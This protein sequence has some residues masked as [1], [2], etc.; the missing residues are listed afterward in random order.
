MSKSTLAQSCHLR[1]K[2]D[3]KTIPKEA[4]MWRLKTGWNSLKQSEVL[5]H[6][7]PN[8]SQELDKIT[9]LQP[10]L[11]KYAFDP[12]RKTETP[13]PVSTLTCLSY[14]TLTASSGELST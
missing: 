4:R 13:D 12:V 7:G 11:D 14:K 5:L 8:A 6:N 9:V 10:R 2:L 1:L 3:G